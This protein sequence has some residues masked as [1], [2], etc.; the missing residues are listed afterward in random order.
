MSP[1]RE[2]ASS[3]KLRQHKHSKSYS[4]VQDIL[5]PTSMPSAYSV[6]VT[7]S[8]SAPT[9]MYHTR[10]APVP[11]HIP[12]PPAGAGAAVAAGGGYCPSV[13]LSLRTRLRATAVA[14]RGRA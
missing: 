8:N 10:D 9:H 1:L 5:F 13:E 3:L 6:A 2:K 7:V 4:G 12:G 14:R 11:G